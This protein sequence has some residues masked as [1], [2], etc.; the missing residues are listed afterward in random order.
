M[1]VA[2]REEMKAAGRKEEL[3]EPVH[4]VL[5]LFLLLLL[6]LLLLQLGGC[7]RVSAVSHLSGR[8]AAVLT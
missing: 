7:R 5:L 4:P 6:L 2:D 8:G 1:H 3:E